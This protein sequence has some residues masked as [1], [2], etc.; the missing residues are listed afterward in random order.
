MDQS[1]RPVRFNGKHP[2]KIKQENP[3]KTLLL[4]F[5]DLSKLTESTLCILF[6]RVYRES[7]IN[8]SAVRSLIC[9]PPFTVEFEDMR[10]A[11]RSEFTEKLMCK[12]AGLQYPDVT[13]K[14]GPPCSTSITNSEYIT[15]NNDCA[16]NL[17]KKWSANRADPTICR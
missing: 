8:C 4:L 15:K 9:I 17:V 3:K 6:Y 12:K 16:E 5:C 2:G 11:L 13:S 1:G 7:F 10:K 14:C